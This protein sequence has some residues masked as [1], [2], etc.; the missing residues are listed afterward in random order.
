MLNKT[1]SHESILC[2]NDDPMFCRI[3]RCCLED[4]GF[5]VYD[6]N[7]GKEGLKYFRRLKPDLVL[8]DLQLSSENGMELLKSINQE[9]PQTP[10][11]VMSEEKAIDEVIQAL[12]IGAWN[13][14]FKPISNMAVVEHTV[15]RVL[16]HRRLLID[17]KNHRAELEKKNIE[18]IQNI[19][20]LKTDQKAGESIQKLLFPKSK[21]QYEGYSFSHKV[22]PSLYLSGDLVD[23]FKIHDDKVGFYIADISGHGASSTF[24]SILLKDMMVKMIS[25]FEI[26]KDETILHPERVLTFISNEI[27]S[28]KLNKYIT[29]I[30]CV[31]D[32]KENFML[33]SIGGHNPNPLI[34]DGKTAVYLPGG[35]LVLGICDN[36]QYECHRF[37]LPSE[38]SLALLSDGI[39]EKMKGKSYVENEKTLL[40]HFKNTHLNAE[41]IL[42]HLGIKEHE[43]LADDIT[44]LL[45]NKNSIRNTAQ[46]KESR[47]KL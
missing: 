23:Y 2:I 47:S 8:T 31:L 36:T 13:Y 14:I 26:S 4:C 6:A 28:A 37:N 39:F 11:I 27:V 34:C 30:Y 20:E 33:Y 15:C 17:N 7:Y 35:G 22:L 1:A 5:K 46:N 32:L 45:M 25:N 24:I 29:M 21:F 19:E 18:L 10:I 44:L 42:T 12:H 3:L 41:K 40:K 38:F 9:S 43:H 16:E